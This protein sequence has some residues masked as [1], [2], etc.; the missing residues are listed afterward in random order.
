MLF[1]SDQVLRKGIQIDRTITQDR[2]PGLGLSYC[3]LAILLQQKKADV[4][5]AD[6][7]WESCITY[8]LPTSIDQYRDILTY[9]DPEVVKK[10]NT[11]GILRES[12][13]R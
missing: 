10:L 4:P 2:E 13:R 12:S 9:A 11:S 3:Y 6:Q 1:R 7:Q 8:A 5:E